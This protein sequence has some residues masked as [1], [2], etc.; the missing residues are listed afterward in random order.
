M[1]LQARARP[2][3]SRRWAEGCTVSCWGSRL[4]K[5]KHVPLTT[6]SAYLVD[7]ASLAAPTS[8][9]SRSQ[10]ITFKCHG[11]Y[12]L[13]EW[14]LGYVNYISIRLFKNV[15]RMGP[16]LNDV[17]KEA[18]FRLLC[19]FSKSSR[20]ASR[21]LPF[22]HSNSH[23]PLLSP[24]VQFPF[25]PWSCPWHPSLHWG[26]IKTDQCLRPPRT[27][28]SWSLPVT[29]FP[30]LLSSLATFWN[31]SFIHHRPGESPRC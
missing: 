8:F 20:R 4:I 13:N 12:T 10:Y 19:T 9:L 21:L 30:A 17:L 24:P 1:N 23:P 31:F 28:L 2:G 16:L 7:F 3:R 5:E 6:F 26:L 11:I 22:F 18:Q 29:V 14:T 15:M 27:W 25:P